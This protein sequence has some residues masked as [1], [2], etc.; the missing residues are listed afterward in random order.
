MLTRL[1]RPHTAAENISMI[2]QFGVGFYSA[3]LIAE[4]V[5]VT[6]K[7]SSVL[8]KVYVHSACTAHRHS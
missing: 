8:I 3:F 6:S 1:S 7:V 2:G 4:S 5:T